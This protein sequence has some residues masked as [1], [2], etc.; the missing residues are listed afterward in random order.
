MAGARLTI[1]SAVVGLL[2]STAT[3]QGIK[4]SRL[5]ENPLVT[6]ASSPTLGTNVNGPTVIR[7]P[8]WVE[9]PLGRYYMYFAN[10][11]GTFIRL[12]YADRVA[13]PWKIHEPGVLQARDTAFYRPQPD[14]PETLDDF[15]THVASPEI[16]IDR[17]HKRL[18]MWIHGWWTNGERWPA[19]PRAAAAWA[20]ANGYGQFTQVADS[21]DGL[22]FN[23]HTPVTKLSYLRVFEHDRRWYG[24]ARLGTLARTSDP[25]LQFE[26]GPNP[27]RDTAYANRIRH[28]SVLRRGMRLHVFFTAIGDAP[29]HVL[30]STIE[31]SGDWSTWRASTPEAVLWPE[32][33]Y[34]CRDRPDV[35]SASG[36]V[37]EPVK[38]IRDPFVFDDEGQTFLFYAI[39]GEQGIAA[40]R[41]TLR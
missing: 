31:L 32:A 7:V 27:F 10:H 12:A 2:G 41:V 9:H 3:A 38:Q 26:P 1:A 37:E 17:E 22:H 20:R 33:A 4:A 8:E 29:E 11:M 40:A 30:M 6:V 23:V 14:P 13:G 39:C 15:Y 35:P 28:V 34:E 16:V 21:S 36:D 24:M 5:A 25:R 19:E 18:L